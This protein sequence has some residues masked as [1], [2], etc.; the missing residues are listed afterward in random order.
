MRKHRKVIIGNSGRAVECI[1][2]LEL[3]FFLA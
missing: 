2:L 1:E 3:V